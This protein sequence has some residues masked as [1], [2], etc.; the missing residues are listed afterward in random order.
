ML[1]DCLQHTN[2][3]EQF[4]CSQQGSHSSCMGKW[5]GL[6]ARSSVCILIPFW[7]QDET[8]TLFTSR[9]RCGSKTD[10]PS[11]GSRSVQPQ[12]PQPQPS[13]V[14]A[15]SQTR[16]TKT[17]KT[18]SP[19]TLTAQEGRARTRCP[20]ATAADRVLPVGRST[21]PWTDRWTRRRP[22]CPAAWEWQHR[23]KAGP[24][25]RAPSPPSRTRWE[26]RSPAYCR[27]CKDRTEPKLH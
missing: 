9:H 17:A 22:P 20:P 4:F 19:P 7:S 8:L 6:A 24:P 21:P 25:P 13:P 3:H 12:P 14:P 1:T 18:P 15:R 16:E 27:L 10:A 11:S 2:T 5:E 26:A 23:A